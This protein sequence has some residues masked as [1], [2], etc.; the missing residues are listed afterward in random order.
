MSDN[1]ARHPLLP[2]VL[3]PTF[4]C[5]SRCTKLMEDMEM[6]AEAEMILHGSSALF[7]PF[8]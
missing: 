7:T 5:A 8:I 1:S 3:A 4:K 6:S 2:R